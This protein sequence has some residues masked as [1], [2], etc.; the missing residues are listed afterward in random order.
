MP[1]ER[2]GFSEDEWR[3]LKELLTHILIERL[4]SDNPM[5][6][7]SELTQILVSRLQN[8][9]L[10]AKTT[11]ILT[12]ESYAL[13]TILGEISTESCNASPDRGML[14]VIVVHKHGDLRPGKGFFEC[15]EKLGRLS[16]GSSDAEKDELWVRE[17]HLVQRSYN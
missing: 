2:Y 6:A 1:R 12:P 5:I 3:S 15:A 4:G 14:T 16:H 11:D 13:A 17:L 7:Y 10:R 8:P 9:A